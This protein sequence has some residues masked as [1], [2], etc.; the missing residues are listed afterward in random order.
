M[1]AAPSS[2]KFGVVG[3]PARDTKSADFAL[4]NRVLLH[5]PSAQVRAGNKQCK[6]NELPPV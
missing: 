5:G 1:L 6:L 4:P 3:A 2:R